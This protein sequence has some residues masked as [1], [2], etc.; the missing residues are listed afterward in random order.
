M[1]A[2]LLYYLLQNCYII[3]FNN[4]LNKKTQDTERFDVNNIILGRQ[5][6]KEENREKT[7]AESEKLK[8]HFYLKFKN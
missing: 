2:P 1:I 5:I 6:H 7:W 8:S 4:K 3:Y